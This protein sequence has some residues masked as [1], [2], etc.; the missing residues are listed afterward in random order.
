MLNLTENG[1]LAQ[2]KER[3]WFDRSQCKEQKEKPRNELRLSNV[4]GIFFILIGGLILA[5]I[6]ALIEFCYIASVESKKAKVPMSDAMK[7]KARLALSGG[8]DIDNIRFYGDSS[9]L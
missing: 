9:A 2:L 8:R 6:T 5:M 1:D 4:A 3:W 7:N